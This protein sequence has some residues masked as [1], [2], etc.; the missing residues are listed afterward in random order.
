MAEGFVVYQGRY[1]YLDMDI[2]VYFAIFF[3]GLCFGSFLNVLL[4]RLDKKDGIITGR[5][6]CI[7][8]L[9]RLEWYDLIPLISYLILRSRCRYCR[10]RISFI[11]PLTELVTAFVI[12]TY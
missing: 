10:V 8:C 4:F 5:S 9:K 11:Y 3:I 6:E 12:T 2:L 7:K 1:Y